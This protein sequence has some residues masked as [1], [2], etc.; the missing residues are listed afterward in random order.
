MGACYRFIKKRDPE[1]ERDDHG[2][3][4]ILIRREN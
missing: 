3:Q 1:S 4:A 2:L